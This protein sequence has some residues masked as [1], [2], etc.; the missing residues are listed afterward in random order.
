MLISR[1]CL[2]VMVTCWHMVDAR[3]VCLGYNLRCWRWVLGGYD[4]RQHLMFVWCRAVAKL[5][6]E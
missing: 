6:R 2:D 4:W 3:D 5:M 1:W